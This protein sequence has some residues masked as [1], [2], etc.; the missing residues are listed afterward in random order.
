VIAPEARFNL[1]EAARSV[2]GLTLTARQLAALRWYADELVRWNARFNLTAIT[3]P[4]EIEAKHFLDSLTCL[5]VMKAGLGGRVVDVGTGAGFPGIPL[6][7]VASGLTLTLVEA[8]G[9]KLDFCRHV[10]EGLGLERVELVQGRAEE[11]GRQ[12]EHREAYDWAVA[13]A[14]APMAVLVEYLLPLVR[15]GGN[16]LA[17]KGESGPAEA[18]SAEGALRILGGEVSQ[19]VSLER[20]GVTEGRFL[21]VVR[22]VA[23]TPSEYPR[24]PGI[25]AKRPLR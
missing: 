4:A 12:P 18:Q 16:A 11:I 1:T 9:K 2:L 22:K 17:Q 19:V 15:L 6:K 24:R 8:T 23:R 13:R 7:I 14:V 25:P 5:R 10:V 3:D 20:P 21:V